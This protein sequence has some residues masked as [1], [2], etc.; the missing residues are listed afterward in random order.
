MENQELALGQREITPG[1]Q[2]P[3]SSEELDLLAQNGSSV[4]EVE[5]FVRTSG[6]QT[7]NAALSGIAGKKDGHGQDRNEKF[8]TQAEADAQVSRLPGSEH[9]TS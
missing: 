4:M 3:F 1:V 7:I 2:E 6:K 8:Q 5:E 9:A